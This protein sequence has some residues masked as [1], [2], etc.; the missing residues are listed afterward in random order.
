MHGL[1]A[2]GGAEQSRLY[3]EQVMYTVRNAAPEQ[4][5]TFMNMYVRGLK[6]GVQVQD[7][8]EYAVLFQQIDLLREILD[9]YEGNRFW[10]EWEKVYR[11]LLSVIEGKF[12][13]EEVLEQSH[14]LKSGVYDQSLQLRLELVDVSAYTHL[15]DYHK[16]GSLL[17]YFSKHLDQLEPNFVKSALKSRIELAEARFLLFIARDFSGAEKRF[18]RVIMNN[19]TPSALI[20]ASYRDRGLSL[21]N[22]AL[23]EKSNKCLRCFEIAISRAK[24][25]GLM[26]EYERLT[27]EYYPLVQNLHGEQ[28]DATDIVQEEVAHQHIVRGEHKKALYLIEDLEARGKGGVFISFYKAKA[29]TNKELMSRVKQQFQEENLAYMLPIVEREIQALDN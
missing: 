16:V 17:D 5:V 15:G 11:F 13:H 20:V 6:D 29:L 3:F 8:L 27:K 2:S 12:T 21:L 7:S 23:L 26:R 24:E 1:A 18:S 10:E 22:E 19:A 25:F 4:L 28:F 14:L 9:R